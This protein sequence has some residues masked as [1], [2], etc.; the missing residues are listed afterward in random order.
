MQPNGPISARDR[1]RENLNFAGRKFGAKVP[2]DSSRSGARARKQT[3]TR[4][5]KRNEQ[6]RNKKERKKEEDR[7]E[8]K[9]VA[10]ASDARAGA[11]L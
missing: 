3:N 4:R 9:P 1:P 7:K 11:E 6:V 8:R 10:G 2:G 5:K